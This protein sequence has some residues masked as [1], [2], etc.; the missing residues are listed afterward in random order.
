MNVLRLLRRQHQK[1]PIVAH[2]KR[3]EEL[4]E[5]LEV[6]LFE[7]GYFGACCDVLEVV[8]RYHVVLRSSVEV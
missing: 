7:L 4:L 5:F 1:R 6:E 2:Q 8:I 3:D